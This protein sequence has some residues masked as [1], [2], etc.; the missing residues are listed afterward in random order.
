MLLADLSAILLGFSL[1]MYILLDGT[2]LGTGMLFFWF[3]AEEQREQMTHTLLPVW[4]ANE[5]WLV[6]LAGGMF[7]LFP[8]AFSLM[9]SS[10]A[11]P[12]FV[13]LLCLFLRAL[14][15][16]YRAEAGVKLKRWL[17]RLM[18]TCSG[19]AAM[20]QG[21]CMNAVLSTQPDAMAD[22]LSLTGFLSGLGLIAVYLLMACCWV[23]WRLG[24]TT[25]PLAGAWCWVWWLVSLLIFAVLLRFNMHLWDQCWALLIGKLVIVMATVAACLQVWGLWRGHP[26]MLLVFTQA[27]VA[28]IFLGGCIGMHP[29][30]LMNK[31]DIYQGAAPQTAQVF[32]L[33][34]SAIIV[35]LTLI[36][37]SWSFWVMKRKS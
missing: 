24:E 2:D 29:W 18:M 14:A 30:I 26:L 33:I 34:G 1:L 8:A 28:L 22:I 7:A 12:V 16:E 35:P 11:L 13:M 31:L 23:R 20:I 9:M 36:Y 37:H 10:L 19:L 4:D 6:L 3:R 25:V 27:L 21:L 32:V 5:T 17:D 15:L